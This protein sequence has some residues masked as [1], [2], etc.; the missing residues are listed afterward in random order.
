M[1]E[2]ASHSGSRIDLP[3]TGMS[4]ASCAAH[5]Q[6]GLSGLKGVKSASVNFAAEKATIFYDKSLVSVDD[7][8][9]TI[10]DQGYDVS[11]SKIVLPVKGMSCASCV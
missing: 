9:H 11:I 3:V 6:E 1:S 5:I 8:I 7:F 10:K 2:D 4:C